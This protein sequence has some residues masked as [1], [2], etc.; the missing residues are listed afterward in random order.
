[1]PDAAVLLTP[2][3]VLGVLLLLGFAGCD[4]E[5]VLAPAVY[6]R[7]RVPTAL[8][9]TE[10]VY[11]TTRPDGTMVNETFPDP[12]PGTTQGT[13][14]LFFLTVG[15]P[16]AGG[17]TM[18]C[19]VSVRENGATAQEAAQTTVSIDPMSDLLTATFAATGTPSGGNFDVAF[20]GLE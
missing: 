12:M 9:V 5:A 7:I 2:V 11:R 17:W 3:L 10:L 15:P 4:F 13:D 16:Q 6:F 18:G 1:V 8:T 20:T 19:R 14:N